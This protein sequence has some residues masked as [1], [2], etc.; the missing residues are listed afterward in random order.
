MPCSKTETASKGDL[1]ELPKLRYKG[2]ELSEN[3]EERHFAKERGI[4]QIWQKIVTELG[5]GTGRKS[6]AESIA[7]REDQRKKELKKESKAISIFSTFQI[8][9]RFKNE[10]QPSS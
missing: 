1:P 3:E 7:M 8:D 2:M 6:E 10:V 5:K 9:I 4:M